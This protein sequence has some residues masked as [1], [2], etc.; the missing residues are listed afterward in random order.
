MKKNNN[1]WLW[2]RMLV[3]SSI[4]I[5]LGI[6]VLNSLLWALEW[7]HD[8]TGWNI[9]LPGVDHGVWISFLGS[10]FGGI[11]GVGGVYLTLTIS[12]QKDLKD[13]STKQMENFIFRHEENL[14]IFQLAKYK[15]IYSEVQAITQN[16]DLEINKI[17][18][19]LERRK[20]EMQIAEFK[21]MVI[22]NSIDDTKAKELY[23]KAI[24]EIQNTSL[25]II[26]EIE[27]LCIDKYKFESIDR[28]RRKIE[29]KKEELKEKG[30]ILSPEY[31]KLGDE[32]FQLAKERIG[33]LGK[34]PV[35]WRK[36]NIETCLKAVR[37]AG[38]VIV[39]EQEKEINQYFK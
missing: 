4:C 7:M 10:V 25:E 11:I 15:V 37:V 12:K 34:A 5:I 16:L 24:Q 18:A 23:I 6:C 17:Q 28:R 19:D 13:E 1:Y 31:N 39:E 22:M 3:I 33:L 14:K 20:A 21:T 35:D 27:K 8:V 30:E 26:L 9:N 32:D 38:K 29:E 36:F 2:V